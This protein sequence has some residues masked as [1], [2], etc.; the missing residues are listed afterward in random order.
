MPKNILCVDD[1]PTIRMLLKKTLEPLGYTVYLAENGQDGIDQAKT[2]D[3][4]MIIM[5]VNMPVLGGFDAVKAIKELPGKANTPVVFLTTENAV[6]KKKM[7]KDLGV[8]GWIVKPF[9]PASL[10][11]VIKSLV[12]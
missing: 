3:L 2:T 7:G 1:S 12:G 5:D 10:E 8:Q 9:E 6:D 4:S 11:K